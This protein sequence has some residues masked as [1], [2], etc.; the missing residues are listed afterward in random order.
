LD[1]AN[2]AYERKIIADIALKDK[3]DEIRRLKKTIAEHKTEPSLVLLKE[4]K[5]YKDTYNIKKN[6]SII[7]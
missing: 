2:T 4:R 7:S 5:Q 1:A 6:N 3:D